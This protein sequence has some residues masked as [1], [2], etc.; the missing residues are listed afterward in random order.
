MYLK[1]TLNEHFMMLNEVFQRS[2]FIQRS[3]KKAVNL[4]K[5]VVSMLSTY[6]ILGFNL[7]VT[8]SNTFIT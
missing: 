2:A 8:K 3:C 7:I 5:H 6:V 4:D 1:L